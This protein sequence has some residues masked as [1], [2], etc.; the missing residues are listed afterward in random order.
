M[1]L[2]GDD[3]Q[4]KHSVTEV[5]GMGR[6]LFRRDA[7]GVPRTRGASAGHATQTF[8]EFPAWEFAG[9]SRGER[10]ARLEQVGGP[11]VYQ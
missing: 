6:S 10:R 1:A 3:L 8:A 4:A 9:A 7:R 11:T 2:S 5:A